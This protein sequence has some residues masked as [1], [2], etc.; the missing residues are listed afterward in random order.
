MM[1]NTIAWLSKHRRIVFEAV[2]WLSVAL[3]ICWSIFLHHNNKKLSERLEMASNNIE[4][5]ECM[6]AGNEEHNNVLQLTVEQLKQSNDK[7]IQQLDSTAKANK[8]K[9][10]SVTSLATQKQALS[11]KG[12]KGVS[13]NL[14]EVLKDT[15]YTDSIYYNKYTKVYYTIG[16]DTVDIYLD[17]LNTQSLYIY[18][19]RE[20]KNK[21]SFIKRLLTLDFKRVNKHKY[22]IINSNELINTSDVRIIEMVK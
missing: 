19:Q 7:L 17:I 15:T 22:T 1:L 10:S 14:I 2:S 5:Y 11:V 4:A 21:K 13:H 6:I 9:I 16:K 12:G 3:L 20:Y 8:V 18:K